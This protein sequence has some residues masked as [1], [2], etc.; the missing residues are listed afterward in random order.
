MVCGEFDEVLQIAFILKSKRHIYI[1]IFCK[2]SDKAKHNFLNSLFAVT[3][4]V[5]GLY[6]KVLNLVPR[7]QQIVADILG[8]KYARSFTFLIG[9]AEILLGAWVISG[10]NSRLTAI[11]QIIFIAI[12]NALEFFLVPNL[13]LWGKFNSVFALLLIITIYCNEFYLNKK[14]AF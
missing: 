7:H 11:L 1:A 2:M 4:I 12:M 9:L 13:L 5:N 3:W 6:C 8:A 10:R 14:P